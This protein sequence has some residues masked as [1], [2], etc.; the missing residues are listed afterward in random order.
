MKSIQ[1]QKAEKAT[2]IAELLI[3]HAKCTANYLNPE[4]PEQE[5]QLN[6]VRAIVIN[7]VELPLVI[8]Q[9][10]MLKE[11]PKGGITFGEQGPEVFTTPNN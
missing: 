9:P 3:E 7:D 8:H 4:L 5:R 10:I 2:R 1:E 11:Y 6:G